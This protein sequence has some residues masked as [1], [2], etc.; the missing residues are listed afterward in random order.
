MSLDLPVCFHFFFVLVFR[1]FR[2]ADADRLPVSYFQSVIKSRICFSHDALYTLSRCV[3]VQLRLYLMR[4]VDPDE[5][6]EENF[7]PFVNYGPA[8]RLTLRSVK[9]VGDGEEI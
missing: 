3:V 4:Y 2:V 8:G 6:R 7:E 9:L 1:V 5:F